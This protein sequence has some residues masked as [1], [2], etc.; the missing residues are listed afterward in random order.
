MGLIEEIP[1][2]AM[3]RERR[4]RKSQRRRRAKVNPSN[5]NCVD[6]EAPAWKP[7]AE[8][9]PCS[10]GSVVWYVGERPRPIWRATTVPMFIAM[11]TEEFEAND[12]KH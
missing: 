2:A 11:S 4:S 6:C 7:L 10:C 5:A 3:D 9:P 12:G 8:R 1:E